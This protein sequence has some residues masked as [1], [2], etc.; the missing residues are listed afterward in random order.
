MF[1]DLERL[2]NAFDN[3][4]YVAELKS[5]TSPDEFKNKVKSVLSQAGY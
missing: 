2:L 5:A 4:S 3:D 1:E